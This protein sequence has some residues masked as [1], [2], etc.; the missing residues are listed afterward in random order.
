MYTSRSVRTFMRLVVPT[1]RYLPRHI[2]I[3][4]T[5]SS[6][7]VLYTLSKFGCWLTALPTH[8]L[9][10]LVIRFLLRESE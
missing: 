8:N 7:P 5:L 10:G 9:R 3:P 4:S 2:I 6:C 1:V